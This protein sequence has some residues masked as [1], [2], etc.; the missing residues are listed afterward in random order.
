MKYIDA[1]FSRDVTC[2]R[3]SRR[4]LARPVAAEN[5]VLQVVHQRINGRAYNDPRVHGEERIRRCDCR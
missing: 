2:L 3:Q 1:G 5:A 4:T